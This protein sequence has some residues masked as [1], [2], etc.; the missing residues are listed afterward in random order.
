VKGCTEFIIL[1]E[2]HKIVTDDFISPLLTPEATATSV[3]LLQL[4]GGQEHRGA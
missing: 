2:G 4:P 1:S 3:L